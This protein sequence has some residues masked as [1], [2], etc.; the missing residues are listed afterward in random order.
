MNIRSIVRLA[1]CLLLC[2]AAGA[3]GSAV[4]AP[5]IPGWYAGLAKPAWT[6][7]NAAFPIAWTTLYIMMAFALW[8]LWD[9]HAPSPERTRAIAFF[10]VQLA[11]NAIWSPVFFGLH[12]TRAG[13][14]IIILLVFALA[15]TIAASWRVCR[16]AAWLLA[17]YF[18]S[19]CYAA[20]LNGGIVALN[21]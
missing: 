3:I 8:R 2:A 1:F 21:P 17:P 5:E 12:A 11:L 9:R 20:T 6:P 18:L 7:P 19:V 10:F 13:L 15:A 14:A 4:T 16:L